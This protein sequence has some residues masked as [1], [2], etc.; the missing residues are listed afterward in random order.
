MLEFTPFVAAKFPELT[1]ALLA[2]CKG[3]SDADRWQ[4]LSV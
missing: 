3:N 4:A 2:S 1:R